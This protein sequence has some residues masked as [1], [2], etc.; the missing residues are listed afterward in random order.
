MISKVLVIVFRRAFRMDI[1]PLGSRK[2][3]SRRWGIM[4]V[5]AQGSRRLGFPT[6]STDRQRRAPKALSRDRADK[7]PTEMP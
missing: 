7:D 2:H 4:A 1:H 5:H 6:P 3:C